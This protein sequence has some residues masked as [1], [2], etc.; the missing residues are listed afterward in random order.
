MGYTLNDSFATTRGHCTIG[1][2]RWG[3]VDHGWST[4]NVQLFVGHGKAMVLYFVVLVAP[5]LV[6]AY[7]E[8]VTW[9]HRMVVGR[10]VVGHSAF[11]RRAGLLVL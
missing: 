11:F 5:G 2:A 9:N 10:L 7:T 6:N 3:R 4:V 8:I 1:I